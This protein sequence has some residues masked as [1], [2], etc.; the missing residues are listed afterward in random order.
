MT[1][2][3]VLLL[4]VNAGPE[5][6]ATSPLVDRAREQF[7]GATLAT[8]ATPQT[9]TRALLEADPR[10]DEV[11][12]FPPDADTPASARAW[13]AFWKGKSIGATVVCWG[14]MPGFDYSR[15]LLAGLLCPGPTFF[16]SAAG[17]T[18][19]ARSPRGARMAAR[20]ALT[21][22]AGRLGATLARRLVRPLRLPL[23]PS[24]TVERILWIR[25]DH[26][27]DV[28][29][30]LPA[31]Q[32][33][34]ENFPQAHI[35]TLT[36][37]ASAP[38][39]A[40]LPFVAEALAYDAPRFARG[41]KDTRTQLRRVLR[42]RRYDLA[43]DARGDDAA[44]RITVLSRAPR[45]A[46]P[47][48]GPY[49]SPGRANLAALMTHAAAPAFPGHAVENNRA[50][51]V[52][53]GLADSLPAF[54]W[55]LSETRRQAVGQTLDA[56]DIG[57]APFAVIHAR[58]GHAA[59]KWIPERFAA[60]ADF[61][62]RERGL[63]VLLLGGPDDAGYNQDIMAHV[64]HSSRVHDMAGRFAL[65][66]LPALLSRASLFVG[67]DSGPMHVAAFARIPIV[68]LFLPW[69]APAHFPWN[70]PDA[71]LTAPAG[72]MAQISVAAVLEKIAEKLAGE[73]AS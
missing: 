1:G 49:E 7:G 53:L 31:L 48:S 45:R 13:R 59:K 40:D 17:E 67:V 33:L 27:G 65:A 22:A 24:G 57:D 16:W 25:L 2:Q 4:R 73:R 19:A 68:A 9:E 60:V 20:A 11:L 5:L 56:L 37:S 69:F 18:V 58:P 47:V 32:A 29:L 34:H 71:V 50:L 63:S 12:I 35:D 6:A 36:Q 46:G 8:L 54:R 72:D 43:F 30:S 70:Q 39:L 55:P 62:A 44:R 41:Q 51:L 26:I 15:H 66:D 21:L 23:A 38:L 3:T 52:A 14:G 28:V 42:G 61:L 64:V 10:F